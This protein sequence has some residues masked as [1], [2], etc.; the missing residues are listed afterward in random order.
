MAEQ[1]DIIEQGHGRPARAAPRLAVP[2]QVGIAIV[3]GT[4][5]AVLVA[6]S[7]VAAVLPSAG[8]AALPGPCTLLPA[9][10][11]ASLVPAATGGTEAV[12]TSRTMT[13]EMCTWQA[14]GGTTLSLDVDY[15]SS[16]GLAQQE[17]SALPDASGPELAAAISPVPGIGDQAQAVIGTGS[18]GAVAVYVRVLSGSAMLA[19]GYNS[20]GTGPGGLP[21]GEAI[22]AKLVPASR[23]A[24]SRLPRWP[25]APA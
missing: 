7:I 15:T 2:R 25:P 24:L 22:L 14:A 10:T 5:T 16:E 19:I 6:S 21:G 18:P 9:A 11:V 8:R 3:A 23:D 17:F 12:F 20:A 13:M 1:P 4:A